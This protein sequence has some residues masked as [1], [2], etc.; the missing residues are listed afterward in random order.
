MNISS[1]CSGC[2]PSSRSTAAL[3]CTRSSSCAYV[4][5]P[6]APVSATR[7][8]SPAATRRS[9]RYSHALNMTALLG[10]VD[11]VVV[12]R[13]AVDALPGR[14]D[15]GGDL[16]AL[17]YRLHERADVALV[18]PGRQP[19]ALAALPFV[20]GDH[21]PVRC[22]L[23]AGQRADAAVERDVWQLQPPRQAGVFE[24]LV[25]AVDAV[26]A[27]ADVFA[28]QVGVQPDERGYLNLADRSINESFHHDRVVGQLV[29]VA[30]ALLRPSA[31]QSRRVVVRH[32]GGRL[33]PE[34]V[35]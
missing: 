7:S 4:S 18:H 8:L 5:S 1:R 32:V 35:E 12:E 30:P 15:P 28:A 22:G 24:D 26:L 23:D 13:F 16:A 3:R 21:L 2:R 33:R 11:V 9:S 10:E 6:A 19:L 17:V 27:V 34:Q 25:P 20:G 14:G 31:L 29:V